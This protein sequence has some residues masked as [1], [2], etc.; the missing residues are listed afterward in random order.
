MNQLKYFFFFL[1]FFKETIV[2]MLNLFQ[3]MS[4]DLNPNALAPTDTP[5]T[6]KK[7]KLF[8]S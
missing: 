5:K 3:A 8:R 2:V 1:V 7:G 6:Q 4:Y